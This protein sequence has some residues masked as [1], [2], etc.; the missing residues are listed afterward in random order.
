MLLCMNYSRVNKCTGYSSQ[1][2]FDIKWL[3]VIRFTHGGMEDPFEKFE[4]DIKNG[5]SKFFE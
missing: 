3:D 2:M 4:N 5:A 1:A